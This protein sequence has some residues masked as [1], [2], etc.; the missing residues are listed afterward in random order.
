M[1]LELTCVI[2]ALLEVVDFNTLNP[3]TKSISA[4]WHSLLRLVI[5]KTSFTF[6]QSMIISKAAMNMMT[7]INALSSI[8]IITAALTL[9][10]RIVDELVSSYKEVVDE[11]VKK[12][13]SFFE[14]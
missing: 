12:F 11:V 4:G 9:K 8:I 14:I 2:P 1:I 10:K 3:V 6:L 5:A 7:E 13:K